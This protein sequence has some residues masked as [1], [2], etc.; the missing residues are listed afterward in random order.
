MTT[1]RC[2]Y[3]HRVW[4]LDPRIIASGIKQ[5]EDMLRYLFWKQP[6]NPLLKHFEKTL[7]IK[8]F[9]DK[10]YFDLI[11]SAKLPPTD[12]LKQSLVQSYIKTCFGFKFVSKQEFTENFAQITNGCLKKLNWNNVLVVGGSVLKSIRQ[13]TTPPQ[14]TNYYSRRD[15]AS[16][17]DIYLYGLTKKEAQAKVEEIFNSIQSCWKEKI[18]IFKTA[19]TITLVSTSNFRNIQIILSTYASPLEILLASDMN[20]CSIGFNGTSVVVIPRFLFGSMYGSNLLDSSTKFG[21]KLRWERITKYYKR[22]YNIAAPLSIRVHGHGSFNTQEKIDKEVHPTTNQM[23]EFMCLMK[24]VLMRVSHGSE[25][26]GLSRESAFDNW[27]GRWARGV[28]IER[29]SD[30]EGYGGEGGYKGL[31]VLLPS[32]PEWIT[33]YYASKQNLIRPNIREA[34]RYAEDARTLDQMQWSNSEQNFDPSK[35]SDIHKYVQDH[36]MFDNYNDSSLQCFHLNLFVDKEQT[37]VN[38]YRE[39]NTSLVGVNYPLET[40]QLQFTNFN[41]FL[42]G[43]VKKITKKF[44][45]HNANWKFA[46]NWGSKQVSFIS[47]TKEEDEEDKDNFNDTKCRPTKFFAN[48]LIKIKNQR[49][50]PTKENGH[51]G[52]TDIIFD[53]SQVFTYNRPD[54]MWLTWVHNKYFRGVLNDG[55]EQS[56]GS[57]LQYDQIDGRPQ[58][59]DKHGNV[60]LE[61]VMQFIEPQFNI[62]VV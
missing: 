40:I 38:P 23:I 42:T 39:M 55:G 4:D 36:C 51:R 45:M 37:V 57:M 22:G 30:G 13:E 27:P 17:I 16:D 15:N 52:P 35:S 21:T 54:N 10:K 47:L 62:T 2:I 29:R 50:I 12:Q 60:H 24:M 46:L 5:E 1:L 33:K 49:K 53:G 6:N 9:E 48:F 14:T 3:Q 26:F 19:N 25:N 59:I 58:Y 28:H 43:H 8:L 11:S 7:V 31:L 41:D 34:P 32:P 18:G 56:I 20:S 44:R 61:L